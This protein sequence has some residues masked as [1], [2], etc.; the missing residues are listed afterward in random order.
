MVGLEDRE[1]GQVRN[2]QGRVGKQRGSTGKG[3]S[4]SGWSTERLDR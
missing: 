1:V 3:Q 4:G 2:N